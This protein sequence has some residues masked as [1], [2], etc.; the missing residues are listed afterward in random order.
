MLNIFWLFLILFLISFSFFIIRRINFKVFNLKEILKSFKGESLLGLFMTLGTKIG[1]GSI[2]GTTAM[3]YVGG[4]G[5]IFWM[6]IFTLITSSLIYIEVKIGS[7]FKEKKEDIYL[8]GPYFIIKNGI[9]NKKLATIA[10]LILVITYSL[11][12]LMI[13]TNTIS[14]IILLNIDISKTL[15]LIILFLFL[16]LTV[17][18]N[19]KE[20]LNIMNYIVPCMCTLFIIISL[21]VIFK[22][23]ESIPY[24]FKDIF[25]SALNPKSFLTGLLIGV[26]RSVFLNELLVGTTSSTGIVSSKNDEKTALIQV[27]GS[28]FITFIIGTLNAFI[29]LIF[30]DKNILVVNNYNE[31]INNVFLSHFGNMGSYL[32]IVLLL[33]FGITTILSGIYIG[34]SNLKVI[35]NN[36]TSSFI[37]KIFV[38]LFSC[39]GLYI[40]VDLIWEIT[41]IFLLVLLSINSYSL[42]KIVRGKYDWK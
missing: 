24:I 37:F 5:S 32:L 35:C 2:I 15:I 7:K 33:L 3:I 29:V 31:L 13:Q 12:F 26:R 22:N 14:S 40:N 9:N 38:I 28:Y 27:F 39:I 11:I 19:L 16:L 18:F 4:A 20:V 8:S 17:I 25:Y 6:W 1:V 34:V 10:T 30:L 21:F 41:D 36:N 42:I 23:I